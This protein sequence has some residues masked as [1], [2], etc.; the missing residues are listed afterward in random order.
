MGIFRI[1]FDGI[2]DVHDLYGISL[3]LNVAM[4]TQ[5]HEDGEGELLRPIRELTGP[6][7]PI[8]VSFNL[9]ANVTPEIVARASSLN[10]FRTYPHIDL[11]D[12]GARAFTSLQH[13]L[14]QGP[15]CKAFRQVPFLVPLTSQHTWSEPCQALYSSL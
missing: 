12:T 8:A 5:D 9:H 7:L 1:I 13:L 11:A 2:R 15:L 6:D 14:T 3:D 10:I 4:V